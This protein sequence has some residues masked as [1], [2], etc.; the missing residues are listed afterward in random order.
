MNKLLL[1]L[2]PLA[3]IVHQAEAQTRQVSGRVT[4]RATG[5]GL[6]GATVLLKGTTTGVSTNSDGT[7]SLS[8]PNEGGTL[9]ISSVGYLSI[10]KAIGTDNQINIGLSA[11]T[12]ELSEVVVTAL[13]IQ[14]EARAIGYATSEVKSEQVVQKSEPDVLRTLQGK[15]AGVN[16]IGSSG[17]PGSSTRIVI[18]GN[19]SLNNNNQPL[20]VVD[21][22]PYDNSNTASDNTLVRGSSYSNRLADIDPNNIESINVLKGMAAAALYGNRGAN[23]VILITTKTGSRSKADKGIRVGFNSSYSIEK[24]ASLPEYQNK[25]G[26]GA[27]FA[28]SAANG[29]WGP[30][31]GSPQAPADVLHPL[32]GIAGGAAAFP[33][34]QGA[35]APYQAYANNVKDFF[36]T[37]KL[38]ENSVNI[39]ASSD[40]A[41]FTT[42]LSRSQQE[43]MIP[44]SKFN[45]TSLSAGGSAQYNKLRIGANLTYTNTDQRGPQLG[46]NNAIGNAS[47]MGRLLFIPRSLDLSGL[48]YENPLTNSSVLG[49]LTGQADNPYW[50]V[51]YNGYTSRVDRLATSANASYDLLKWL[52]LSFTGGVNTYNDNRRSFIRPGSV[53]ASGLGEVI[54]DAITNTELEGTTLLT[55]NQNITD[56][57]SLKAILG[58]NVNQREFKSTS[59]IG[60]QYLLFNIDDIQNTKSQSQ[61][62]SG[63][64]KRRI[65]GVFG[66]VTLGYKDFVYLN[67]TARNEWTSTLAKDNRSFFYPSVSTSLIFTE[68]LGIQSDILNM[69]KLRA[70]YAR[71]GKDANPYQ[72]TSRYTLNPTFGNNAAG[73]SFP[74]NTATSGASIGGSI[75]NPTL[76]PEFS[77]ELEVGTDLNFLKDRII[78]SATYYDK[79]S[80]AQIAAVPLPYAT[81]FTSLVTNFG[82]ISNKGVEGSLTLVPIDAGGFRW[83]SF[84]TFTRNRNIIE[85][86]TDGVEQVIVSAN[87][88][89]GGVQAIHKAGQPYGVIYGTKAARDPQSGKVLINPSTGTMIP[90]TNTDVIGNPNP[91]YLMG[92]TNTFSYKGLTFESVIDFRKGGDV[93]STTVATLLGRGVTKDTEDRDKTLV[94]DGVY[95]NPNT[96]QPL[97]NP[98]GSTIPNTTAVSLNDYY[99]G[100]GSAALSGPAEFSVFDATTVRLREVTLGYTVPA[101]LLQKTPF[102][103]LTLSLSGRNLWWFSPNIPK[104]TNFDPETNT[105]GGASNAQGF[106]YTNAPTARRYGVNLRVNF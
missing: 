16:I 77:K 93:Y 43:G 25:Y 38:F 106:E 34:F 40:N 71:A 5:E 64:S 89:S 52:N 82:E 9:Q 103:G 54:Q 22:V 90:T 69:G 84:T 65:F 79:R 23:G 36:N 37:G 29:S 14:R 101:S 13:G 47:V 19:T 97:T 61:F 57:F 50:S 87:Y 68:A 4:D 24:I 105:Y 58:H 62:G 18:R 86:L 55:V 73:F 60:S 83:T 80:T 98:D 99:F 7:F 100:A 81:G 49:W 31:F 75:G 94:I 102:R 56:D 91:D 6:P 2:I 66:D 1:G 76:T 48:P 33:E 67:A 30:A 27:N 74:F 92:F 17:A 70:G 46:A 28:Q 35:R 32:S 78:L 8:V 88:F 59:V 21:G 45:R 95:G 15:V 10:D 72:L 63:Y 11:D 41:S 53:G 96:Q 104:Y 42:V 12:K 3:A 39:T 26:A 51:K 44:E 20:F 85:K